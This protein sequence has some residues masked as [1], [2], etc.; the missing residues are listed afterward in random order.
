MQGPAAAADGDRTQ[1]QG[2]TPAQYAEAQARSFL[3]ENT[4]TIDYKT[5]VASKLPSVWQRLKN[6][7]SCKLGPV[8]QPTHPSSKPSA[9]WND[10]YIHG[11]V[12]GV[13]HP[14]VSSSQGGCHS[15][16]LPECSSISRSNQCCLASS[17]S[18]LFC[19]TCYVMRVTVQ[20][21]HPFYRKPGDLFCPSCERP[22]VLQGNGIRQGT[23]CALSLVEQEKVFSYGMV[24]KKCPGN[25]GKGRWSLLHVSHAHIS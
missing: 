2:H 3:S 20:V 16:L 19:N 21:T 12:F 15:I 1:L 8:A 14:L 10:V 17:S 13:W 7:G 23:R 6:S 9:C 22:A 25:S 5:G 4:P 24:C 11:Q 18:K